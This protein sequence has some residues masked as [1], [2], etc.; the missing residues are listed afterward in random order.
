[1]IKIN[2]IM[3]LRKQTLATILI[4]LLVGSSCNS[5]KSPEDKNLGL[6]PEYKK[7]GGN[8]PTIL[9]IPCMSCRWNQWESFMDQNKDRYTMYA[10]TIPGE[11]G[12]VVPELPINKSKVGYTPWRDNAILALSNFIDDHNLREVTIMGHSWGVMVAIQLAAKRKDVIT[13]VIGVDGSFE[14]KSWLPAIDDKE[15]ISRSVYV[16]DSTN[17]VLAKDAEE[18]RKMNSATYRYR[19][20][21]IVEADVQWAL[22]LHGSFMATPKHVLHQYWRENIFIDLDALMKSVE[23]PM[24]DIQSFPVLYDDGKAIEDYLKP[25][26]EISAP[27]NLKHVYMYRTAHFIMQHRPNELN[28]IIEKFISGKELK[29]V[30]EFN[31]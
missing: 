28:E 15:G 18:W 30:Y 14:R 3:N 6:I 10:V 17:A 25:F 9:L 2:M 16:A 12:T 27:D 13:R 29:S 21:S 11:G 23:V 22:K 24:L 26:E 20:D 7:V 31:Y 19:K 1:M 5:Q 4:L 8:G